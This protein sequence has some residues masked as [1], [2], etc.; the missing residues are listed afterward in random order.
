M[1]FNYGPAFTCTGW[2]LEGMTLSAG[3]RPLRGIFLNSQFANCAAGS[4]T[5]ATPLVGVDGFYFYFDHRLWSYLVLPHL[6]VEITCGGL[7]PCVYKTDNP[8]FGTAGGEPARLST[9]A[10]QNLTLLNGQPMACEA[11]GFWGGAPFVPVPESLKLELVA[12]NKLY[13]SGR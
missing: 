4:C 11:S 6:V 12:P 8:W 7:E 13:I 2:T 9:V 10:K 3:G 5:V 1:K